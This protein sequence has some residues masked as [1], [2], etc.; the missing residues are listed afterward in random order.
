MEANGSQYG[1]ML[2]G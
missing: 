2:K 1:H